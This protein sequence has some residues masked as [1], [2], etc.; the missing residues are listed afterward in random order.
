MEQSISVR[1]SPFGPVGYIGVVLF[2]GLPICMHRP[3]FHCENVTNLNVH[4]VLEVLL[5]LNDQKGF[6]TRV[7]GA[8][9]AQ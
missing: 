9:D 3:N 2:F 8:D 1:S 7:A 5:N 4:E 6:M